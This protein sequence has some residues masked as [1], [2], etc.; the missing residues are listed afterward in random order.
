MHICTSLKIQYTCMNMNLDLS[1]NKYRTP[2]RVNVYIYE[3]IEELCRRRPQTV[4]R[5]RRGQ[6]RPEEA[7]KNHRHSRGPKIQKFVGTKVAPREEARTRQKR[8]EFA[9]N[10]SGSIETQRNCRNAT[11]FARNHSGGIE[12]NLESSLCCNDIG[13]I[14]WNISVLRNGYKCMLSV[15]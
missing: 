1:M 3:R 12:T 5:A 13:K 11:H 6:R 4:R 15:S 7:S 8:P 14:G 9:R 2:K 10:H